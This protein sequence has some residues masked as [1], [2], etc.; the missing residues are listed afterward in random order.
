MLSNINKSVFTRETRLASLGSLVF[1]YDDET[2]IYGAYFQLSD[3]DL[4]GM[5]QSMSSDMIYRDSVRCNFNFSDRC[6]KASMRYGRTYMCSNCHDFYK[7]STSI[8][9]LDYHHYMRFSYEHRF[10]LGFTK[11]DK[12]FI[13][14]RKRDLDGSTRK[15]LV[16]ITKK[17]LNSTNE[18]SGERYE[19]MKRRY[20]LCLMMFARNELVPDI[21]RIIAV[22]VIR[23]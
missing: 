20:G 10:I 3:V 21:I 15:Y 5:F 13:S 22:M 8:S 17:T 9:Q 14:L 16:K 18:L 1:G 23:S 4:E 12:Y 7:S 6:S 19:Y 2:V 11:D